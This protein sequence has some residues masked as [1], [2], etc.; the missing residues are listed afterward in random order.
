MKET[1]GKVQVPAVEIAAATAV[2]MT[3]AERLESEM[4]C[5]G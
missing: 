2:L 4:E 5:D 1:K 3:T